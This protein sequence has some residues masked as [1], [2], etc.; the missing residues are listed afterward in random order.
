[1]TVQEIKEKL[2]E[3]GKDDIA[4]LIEGVAN[5]YVHVI[6]EA[7]EWMVSSKVVSQ[8]QY[9]A[10]CYLWRNRRYRFS[11]EMIEYQL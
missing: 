11:N 4:D 1:M 10:Y 7:M 2:K 9:E 8:K 3:Q 6:P 5:A